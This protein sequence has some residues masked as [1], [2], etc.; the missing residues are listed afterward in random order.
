MDIK[1]HRWET[2]WCRADNQ[3]ERLEGRNP[4]YLCVGSVSGQNHRVPKKADAP[5][6]DTMNV[7][8]RIRLEER[9]ETNE[10]ASVIVDHRALGLGR[11]RFIQGDGPI[12]DDRSILTTDPVRR[13]VRDDEIVESTVGDLVVVVGVTPASNSAFEI[14]IPEGA[15]REVGTGV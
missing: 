11:E 6:D 7:C 9:L 3:R 8:V 15:V 10:G 1:T 13:R 14:G 4:G 5:S 12:G 2:T